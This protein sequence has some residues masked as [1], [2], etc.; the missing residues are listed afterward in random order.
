M[1][2]LREYVSFLSEPEGNV[3]LNESLRQQR[4]AKDQKYWIAAEPRTVHFYE[5]ADS[6]KHP[7]SDFLFPRHYRFPKN[8]GHHVC[9]AEGKTIICFFFFFSPEVN[10]SGSLG[11]KIKLPFLL[12]SMRKIKL[13]EQKRQQWKDEIELRFDSDSLWWYAMIWLGVS[14]DSH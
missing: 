6:L 7:T 1:V 14:M 8:L 4:Q 11:I 3:G 13:L 10:L 9:T 5:P 12:V 2:S